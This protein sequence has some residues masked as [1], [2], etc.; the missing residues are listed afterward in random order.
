MIIK[1]LSENNSDRF[2]DFVAAFFNCLFEF[3]RVKALIKSE[4]VKMV[5]KLL[6]VLCHYVL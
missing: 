4:V 1:F 3:L 6:L 5:G 2:Q